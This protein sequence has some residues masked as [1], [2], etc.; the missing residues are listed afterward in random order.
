MVP[1]GAG[2]PSAPSTFHHCARHVYV[3]SV[4]RGGWHPRVSQVC[5]EL[6]PQAGLPL[7]LGDHDPAGPSVTGTPSSGEVRET[8]PRRAGILQMKSFLT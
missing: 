7:G 4:F 5:R 6:G 2:G 8:G 1:S 3:C